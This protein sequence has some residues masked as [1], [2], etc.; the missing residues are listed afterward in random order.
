MVKS[1]RKGDEMS[2]EIKYAVYY[3]SDNGYSV[4]K[5]AKE[6]NIKNKDIKDILSSRDTKNTNIKTTSSPV[7]SKDLMINET[8]VKG[9]KS[10][11][12]MT[13]AASEVNDAFRN[14]I[15]NDIRSRTS[16]NAIYRPNQK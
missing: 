16:K 11:S 15:N 14:T 1:C 5:I 3:L 8:S 9:T 13:K 4:A 12:I 6:L 10:V 7:N 2:N